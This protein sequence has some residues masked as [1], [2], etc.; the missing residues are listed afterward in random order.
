[1]LNGRAENAVRHKTTCNNI[2]QITHTHTLPGRERGNGCKCDCAGGV[3][4]RVRAEDFRYRSWSPVL[5]G[6]RSCPGPG[7]HRVWCDGR[8]IF[9]SYVRYAA[10][11]VTVDDAKCQESV[12][13]RGGVHL[14]RLLCLW[15][16]RRQHVGLVFL[17]FK[18]VQDRRPRLQ[19]APHRHPCGVL[20]RGGRGDA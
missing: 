7:R 16:V 13:D 6:T 20:A 12:Q 9:S 4:G 14:V 15:S 2:P 10:Q 19:W 11:A 1:M 3:M 18:E 17:L 8:T 5:P